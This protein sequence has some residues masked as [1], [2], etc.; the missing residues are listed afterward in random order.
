[1]KKIILLI[2]VLASCGYKRIQ[3]R[4]VGMIT[5]SAS[6]IYDIK[7]KAIDGSQIDF[8]IYRGK[9]L[10][11]VNTAS[12][13]GFTP[14]YEDLQRLHAMYEDKITI[15]GFP[16]NDFGGQEPGTNEEI[17]EFCS[18]N[19]QVTFQLFEKSVVSGKNKSALYSWLTIKD[20]NGWNDVEP[21][22]NFCKYL[23]SEEGELINFFGS[24]IDPFSEE[25][26]GKL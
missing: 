14:Q 22:W 25:I 26:V 8:S 15:L 20:Q 4:P 5:Q 19:F 9:K 12:E 2:I 16:S 17:A 6:S 1:M 11:I 18:K 21:N 7:V 24:A 13:C 3:S 10:L 23:V